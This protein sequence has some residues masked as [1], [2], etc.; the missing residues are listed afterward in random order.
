MFRTPSRLLE[1]LMSEVDPFPSMLGI[2][3]RAV[4]SVS[5]PRNVVLSAM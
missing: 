2:E 1:N 3:L 5:L 4:L